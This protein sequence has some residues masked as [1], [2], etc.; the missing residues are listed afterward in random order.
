[1]SKIYY[2]KRL[3]EF[4]LPYL[5]VHDELSYS[6]PRE[7]ADKYLIIAKNAFEEPFQELDN[8]SLPA[9]A[10]LGNNWAEAH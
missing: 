10:I 9:S 1:M 7:S 2:E 6:V 4:S 5:E 8:I 3:D